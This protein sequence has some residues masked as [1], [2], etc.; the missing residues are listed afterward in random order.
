MI[1]TEARQSDRIKCRVIVENVGATV[2]LSEGG[3]CVLMA[4][5]LAEGTEVGL[6]FQLPE[7]EETVHCHGRVVHTGP[8]SID[9]DLYEIGI[10]FLRLMTRHREALGQYVQA[11]ADIRN[12]NSADPPVAE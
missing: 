9:R 6:A 11:R 4:N 8:S 7:S 5:P 10:Q 2:D 1:K 3:M 12:W